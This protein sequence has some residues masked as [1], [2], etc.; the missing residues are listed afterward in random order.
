MPFTSSGFRLRA[1]FTVQTE[2]HLD[3]PVRVAGV[4]VG[5][6]VSIKR[7]GGASP[8]TIVTMTIARSA[9]P[10]HDNATAA[11]RPRLFLEGNYYVSLAPGTPSAPPLAS[12]GLLPAV[13][14]TG[15]V[16]L[17]RILSALNSNT[18][19][20]LQTLLQGVGSAL[21]TPSTAAE[22]ATEE[23]SQRRLTAGQSLNQSL[24]Y[25]SG[26]F[27]ASAIVNEALLGEQPH[28]LS[29]VVTGTSRVLSALASERGHLAHLVTSFNATLGSLAARQHDLS[30]TVRLLPPLLQATDRTLGPLQDSFAPTQRFARYLTPSI[31]QLP[32]TIAAGL[33]WIQQSSDLLSDR[34]LGGLLTTLTPATQKTANTI[35][36]SKALLR[37][38][39]ALARCLTHNVIPTGNERIL[40]PP[41]TT[42]LQDYQELLQ[43][44]VGAAGAAGDF[45]GNGRYTRAIAGGGSTPEVTGS[46]GSQGP[47]YGDA[48]IPTLGTRPAYPGKAPVIR[49]DV[50]C[51]KNAAP[52]LNAVTTG[53][54]P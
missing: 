20:N 42:G 44:A 15:P 2:L 40:D 27:R 10:V 12:G 28:D 33:P 52:N 50:P 47:L 38:T 21:N 17:D 43:S 23:P 18:R 4:D 13:D 32:A 36:A 49:S 45:D 53:T 22:Q 46:L 35:G 31:K 29:G 5:K 48:V 7:E 11:I 8:A 54:G 14:T 6:V 26:A 19:A 34:D 9:L 41:L 39:Q 37:Q 30:Q 24:R 25:A 3:S 16:Q 51:F 1:V